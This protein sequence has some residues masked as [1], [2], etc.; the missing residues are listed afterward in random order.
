MHTC[1]DR[2]IKLSS[3]DDVPGGFHDKEAQAYT[4]RTL[5]AKDNQVLPSE[6]GTSL[7]VRI[8]S[9]FQGP[10]YN[11]GA[12]ALNTAAGL[13]AQ[14]C[15]LCGK[16]RADHHD[17]DDCLLGHGYCHVRDVPGMLVLVLCASFQHQFA[18]ALSDLL[19][20]A[21]DQMGGGVKGI[22][23]G[24]SHDTP[25]GFGKLLVDAGSEGI[26]LFKTPKLPGLPPRV[27]TALSLSQKC[28]T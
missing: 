19:S 5:K 25:S 27:L 12:P 16:T 6:L 22:I 2:K 3:D 9:T 15:Q 24:A 20:C 26:F 11:Y 18:N 1:Y 13:A 14:K 28:L 4:L 23:V 7:F 21:M 17:D 10:Y 8:N